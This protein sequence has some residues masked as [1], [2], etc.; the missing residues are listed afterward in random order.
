M[1]RY[2]WGEELGG[3]AM[4]DESE[5]RFNRTLEISIV[6]CDETKKIKAVIYKQGSKEALKDSGFLFDTVE[7]AREKGRELAREAY[8]EEMRGEIRKD[9]RETCGPVND[10]VS[11]SGGI[12]GCRGGGPRRQSRSGSTP[13]SNP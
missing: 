10:F 7:E 8:T 11:A 13:P 3:F 1:R 6:Q 5:E 4:S 9:F 12:S 2:S